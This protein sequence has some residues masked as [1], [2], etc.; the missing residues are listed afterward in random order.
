MPRRQCFEYEK[1]VCSMNSKP[2]PNYVAWDNQKLERG[3]DK[4]EE[5]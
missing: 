4:V 3:E 1:T 5:R 2:Q